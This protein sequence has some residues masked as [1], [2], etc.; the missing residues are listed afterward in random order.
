[1]PLRFL[2]QGPLTSRLRGGGEEPEKAAKID[3]EAVSK[4]T[5][6][7]DETM[8]EPKKPAGTKPGLQELSSTKN[9]SPGGRQTRSKTDALLRVDESG[10]GKSKPSV[11]MPKGFEELPPTDPQY[12]GIQGFSFGDFPPLRGEV[13]K[14][15]TSNMTIGAKEA[16]SR[17]IGIVE[18][19]KK[20]SELEGRVVPDPK[21]KAKEQTAAVE[22]VPHIPAPVLPAKAPAAPAQ[23]ISRPSPFRRSRF[24]TKDMAKRDTSVKRHVTPTKGK[25]E[26]RMHDEPD[27]EWPEELQATYW[28]AGVQM[29]LGGPVTQGIRKQARA[30][31]KS[32]YCQD[33]SLEQGLVNFIFRG[34]FTQ[35][36]DSEFFMT[37]RAQGAA[38]YPLWSAI[39]LQ[40]GMQWT[41][42][43]KSAR[44]VKNSVVPTQAPV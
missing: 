43:A 10:V 36:L 22:G 19:L 32:D 38:V 24:S 29:V 7:P 3:A 9:G 42:G 20:E 40:D 13:S 18:A 31:L 33:V 5:G 8:P 34:V 16:P 37:H 25:R 41:P 14:N 23:Q 35:G 21:G 15:T 11:E 30:V 1:M 27:G 6:E 12:Q 26:T 39:Y 28:S 2:Q 44:L 4:G 17:D